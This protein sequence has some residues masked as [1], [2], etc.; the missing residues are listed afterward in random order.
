MYDIM[1]FQSSSIQHLRGHFL[2]PGLVRHLSLG[3]RDLN[4]AVTM[5]HARQHGNALL[6]ENVWQVLRMLAAF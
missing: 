6:G 5:K 2:Q 4:G 3:Y 1:S